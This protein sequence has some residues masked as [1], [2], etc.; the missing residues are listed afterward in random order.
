[1]IRHRDRRTGLVG[2]VDG[3]GDRRVAHGTVTVFDRVGKDVGQRLAVVERLNRGVAV[4]QGV[5]VGPTSGDRDRAVAAVDGATHGAAAVEVD[6]GTAGGNANYRRRTIRTGR[7]GCGR[8]RA[9]DD[10]ARHGV[11]AGVFRDAAAVGIGDRGRVGDQNGQRRLAAGLVGAISDGEPDRIGHFPA[12]VVLAAAGRV[13]AVGHDAR[14]AVVAGNGQHAVG[15]VDDHRGGTCCVELR[16]RDVG[17]GHGDLGQPARG[18]DREG[19]AGEAGVFRNSFLTRGRAVLIRHCDRGN[20]FV[21]TVD[22][23]AHCRMAHRAVGVFDRVGKDV[24]QRLAVVQRLYGAVAVV[25]GVGVGPACGDRD[26]AVAAV[27]RATHGAAAV[28]VDACAAGGN[29]NHRRRTVRTRRVGCGRTRAADDVARYGV[30]AGVFRE[31]ATVSIG[32][33]HRV[34]ERNRHCIG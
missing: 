12:A 30:R 19:L 4:V 24:G 21:S 18:A 32:N 7:V 15:G 3:D 31:A 25:Q 26:R 6:A 14:A 16:Q 27:D 22:G 20:R 29:T 9:A 33:R 11:R 1:M 5:G 10:V 13:I 34:G 23:D 8:T 28:E 17:S 2:A